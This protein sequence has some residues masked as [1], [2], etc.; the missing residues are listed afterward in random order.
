MTVE[1]NKFIQTTEYSLS[2]I[3]EKKNIL[4]KI[5][6]CF[7]MMTHGNLDKQMKTI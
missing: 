3:T 4:R 2:L 1:K 7:L 5:D 6:S